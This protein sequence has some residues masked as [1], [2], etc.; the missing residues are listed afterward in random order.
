MTIPDHEVPAQKM[1]DNGLLFRIVVL[2]LL[3]SLI[4][5]Q[6][7][8]LSSRIATTEVLAEVARQQSALGDQ[9][10]FTTVMAALPEQDRVKLLDLAVMQLNN[11]LRR[12]ISRRVLIPGVPDVPGRTYG[13][14]Q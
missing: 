6:V 7:F 1:N 11:N 5:F 2:A 14:R 12:E 9:Q 3:G 10:A 13:G 4:A 8:A